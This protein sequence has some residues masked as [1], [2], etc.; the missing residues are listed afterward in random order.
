MVGND[1][2]AGRE[3]LGRGEVHCGVGPIE[4][5]SARIIYVV[6]VASVKDISDMTIELDEEACPHVKPNVIDGDGEE[7]WR[8]APQA[9]S[10][11]MAGIMWKRRQPLLLPWLS[12]PKGS[13]WTNLCIGTCLALFVAA[14]AISAF[15][16]KKHYG[17]G[18]VRIWKGTKSHDAHVNYTW[19]CNPW[20]SGPTHGLT[21]WP[22]PRDQAVLG[23]PHRHAV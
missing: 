4:G 16:E 15:I 12:L 10:V 11:G 23:L 13:A 14:W 3:S 1:P 20:P 17:A 19:P 18:G 8:L 21:I 6:A 5:S 22:G 9:R 2:I 7:R